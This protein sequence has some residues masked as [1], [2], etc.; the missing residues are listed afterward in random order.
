MKCPVC[1]T[2]KASDDELI[3]KICGFSNYKTDFIN[4]EEMKLWKQQSVYPYYRVWA[5]SHMIHGKMAHV[6]YRRLR[7][8]RAPQLHDCLLSDLWC[9]DYYFNL[10]KDAIGKGMTKEQ[11]RSYITKKYP[12][13][14]EDFPHVTQ[15]ENYRPYYKEHTGKLASMEGEKYYSIIEPV[16]AFYRERF[17]VYWFIN[18]TLPDYPDFNR[19]T[20]VTKE[21]LE[22]LY[23]A[24]EKV[25]Q[26]AICCVGENQ[27]G[28]K[29]YKVDIMHAADILPPYY[30][31]FFTNPAYAAMYAE[32]VIQ[33]AD[34]LQ[35]L[36]NT[37]QF[38]KEKIFFTIED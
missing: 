28:E 12:K 32:R 30:D 17:I 23:N 20:I 37:T 26:E 22:R 8:F 29:E 4:L 25:K 19:T 7:L 24:C 10:E 9:I 35:E 16:D 1:K 33:I 3:C 13:F 14:S 34:E 36:L 5:K 6:Y 15:I 27:R 18:N 38:D 2:D 21:Q 31:A 11:I